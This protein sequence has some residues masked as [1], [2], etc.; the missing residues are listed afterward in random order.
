MV[1]KPC[2]YLV[3][4]V[5]KL[6]LTPA[7]MRGFP[8]FSLLSKSAF[9]NQFKHRKEV[10]LFQII[11]KRQGGRLGGNKHKLSTKC[12]R[13]YRLH[14]CILYG[15]IANFYVNYFCTYLFSTYYGLEVPGSIPG[16]DEIFLPS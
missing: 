13:T 5:S 11:I 7:I 4:S 12:A 3:S 1:S 15:N 14:Y 8:W 6:A 9:W 10:S 2:T 16:G